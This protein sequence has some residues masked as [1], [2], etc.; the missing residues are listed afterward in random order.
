MKDPRQRGI[1]QSPEEKLQARF[2]PEI[3]HL[4]KHPSGR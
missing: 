2:Q 4:C 3:H 1:V